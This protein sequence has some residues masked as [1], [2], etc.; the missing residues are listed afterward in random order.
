MK[1]SGIRIYTKYTKNIKEFGPL[2][3]G[4]L[5][6]FDYA[7][8]H[9]ILIWCKVIKQEED[10]RFWK[11]WVIKRNDDTIGISGLYSLDHKTDKL[12]LGWFGFLREHRNKGMGGLIL[13][14]LMIK[15]KTHGCKE[16]YSYVDSKN[17][18]ALRF[19]KREGFEVISTVHDYCKNNKISLK[20]MGEEFEKETDIIIRK[21]L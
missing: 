6:D 4:L 11:V 8:W 2:F 19:Y 14:W 1:N 9:T 16:L 17:T 18:K 21:I 15:A 7:V 3:D 20:V 12:W 5:K 13:E 10:K